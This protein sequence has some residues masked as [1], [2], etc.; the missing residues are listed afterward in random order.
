MVDEVGEGGYIGVISINQR[1]SRG[2]S[3]VE[4]GS[5]PLWSPALGRPKTPDQ[6]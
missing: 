4:M 5:G 1:S 2:E 3:G 6:R